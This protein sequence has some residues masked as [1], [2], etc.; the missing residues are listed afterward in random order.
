MKLSIALWLCT[1]RAVLSK[2]LLESSKMSELPFTL[3]TDLE[4][5]IAADPTWQQGVSWGIPRTGHLEGPIKYHIADVL[6]NLDRQCLND[7]ER[8]ALR[9]VALVHDTFKYQVDETRPRIGKNHHAYIARKFAEHYIDDPVLLDIIELHDEA[10]NSW[11]LGAYK[12][13]WQHA[14]ERVDHLLKRLGPSLPLY[15]HFFYA[16]SHTESK[17]QDPVIWFKQYL[18]D[19]GLK[20]P[21]C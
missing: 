10:Y 5:R 12:G 19:R 8:R 18:H 13:R 9:L 17:N 11:R 2:F 6:A 1:W 16:D 20:L 21:P 15:V 14:I 3:E 4:K 7:E